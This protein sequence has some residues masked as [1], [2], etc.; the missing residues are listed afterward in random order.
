M[1]KQTK[2][3]KVTVI[4][5]VYNNS[6]YLKLVFA[7]LQRQTFKDFDII[8]A[9]DGSEEGF[10]NGIKM[11]SREIDY[12]LIHLWQEDKGFRKNK[13]L[14]RAIVASN[15]DYLVFTDG[16]CIP[17][18]NFIKEHFENRANGLCLT[19]R[20]V[21]LS[22]KITNRLNAENVYDGFLEKRKVT[23]TIDGIIGSSTDIEKGFY[24]ENKFIRNILNKK[25]RGLLGSNFSIHKKELIAIN[26]FDERY[27]EPSIGE[28]SDLQFRLELNNVQI[29]SLNNIA[30]QYHLFHNILPRPENNMLIFENV[31]KLKEYF[32]PYGIKQTS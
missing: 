1:G 15:S 4:I 2:V 9:D 21:N 26:G 24:F 3:T 31:K 32:T 5:S 19:G 6:D 17:H 7:G 18:K 20:R 30:I 28:D 23:L 14:N 22:Q 8:I 16:D 10:V 11:L 13:I 27:E 12:S 25:K 29:R